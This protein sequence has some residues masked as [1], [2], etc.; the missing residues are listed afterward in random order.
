MEIIHARISR[1]SNV[2]YF[3]FLKQLVALIQKNNADK[4]KVT[5]SV[6]N[7]INSFTGLQAALDKEKS[8]T[9]TKQLNTLDKERD[10][11]ISNFVK[12]LDSMSFY[13]DAAVANHAQDLL[14]YVNSFGKNINTQSH[15]AE[16][17]ILTQIV[18]GIADNNDR[19]AA[20][21]ALNGTLWITQLGTVNAEFASL[22][23]KRIVDTSADKS[24]ESFSLIRKKTDALYQNLI[25]LLE[26]R[27]QTAVY[28]KT[29]TADYETTI[30]EVNELI[31]KANLLAG[32]IKPAPI[33][34][35]T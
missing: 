13:P 2:E 33:T 12:F 9:I 10:T 23:S 29:P 25:K 35:N 34:A 5:A 28:D 27:Y 11:L 21:A 22:Y 1:L 20:L 18:T 6:T 17:T 14:R 3:E 32:G 19:K 30:N 24:I 26:S 15:L 31:A 8:S 16:T 4:L 7:L